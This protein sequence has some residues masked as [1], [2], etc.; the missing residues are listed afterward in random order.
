[1]LSVSLKPGECVTI[2]PDIEVY[3]NDDTQIK[4]AIKAPREVPILRDS[5]KRRE[6]RPKGPKPH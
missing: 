6:P 3:N 4:I 1:M 5:T 2:G